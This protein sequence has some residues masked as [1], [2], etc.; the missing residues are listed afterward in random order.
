MVGP[1][2][3]LDFEAGFLRAGRAMVASGVFL[4][5]ADDEPGDDVG[6]AHRIQAFLLA[7]CIDVGG[8]ANLGATKLSLLV[9]E[10]IPG[11]EPV[12]LFQDDL[13]PGLGVEE[14]QTFLNF[15]GAGCSC[16]AGSGL[17]GEFSSGKWIVCRG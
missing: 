12:M 17:R 1:E 14:G 11:A 6:D 7:F 8:G 13:A 3:K 9:G 2:I 15:R 16:P 10:L 5:A 4:R